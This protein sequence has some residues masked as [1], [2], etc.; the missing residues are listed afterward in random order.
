RRPVLRRRVVRQ[1]GVAGVGPAGA[2]PRAVLLGVHGQRPRRGPRQGGGL[3]WGLGIPRAPHPRS[4]SPS[5]FASLRAAQT[6][7]C[8]AIRAAPKPAA[9]TSGGG[10]GGQKRASDDDSVDMF[11]REGWSSASLTSSGRDGVGESRGGTGGGIG[12]SV[13]PGVNRRALGPLGET[14]NSSSSGGG[15]IGY[16]GR[17]IPETKAE[18]RQ[19][20]AKEK[21]NSSATAGGGDRCADHDEMTSRNRSRKLNNDVCLG[22]GG[23]VDYLNTQQ[24]Q[25]REWS[26]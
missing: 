21:E 12:G 26:L 13:A 19:R 7:L 20:V 24:E 23:K 14:T 5:A 6:G 9:G 17:G 2:G 18:R 15:G 8:D 1:A 16:R 25:R 11:A 22:P 10:A 3:P 4:R